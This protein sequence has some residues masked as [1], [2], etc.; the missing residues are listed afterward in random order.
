MLVLVVVD[1]GVGF[2]LHV[3]RNSRQLII[4]IKNIN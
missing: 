4:C 2:L 1:V 3:P